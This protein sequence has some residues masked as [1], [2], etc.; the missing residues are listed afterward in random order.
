MISESRD[1]AVYT[2]VTRRL[3][4]LR[5]LASRVRRYLPFVYHLARTDMKGEHLDTILGQAWMV[6]NPLLMAGVYY[7][8]VSILSDSAR[9]SAGFFSLLVAGLFLFF[10]CRNSLTFGSS[11]I[12]KG[13]RLILNA[14][15]PRVLLPMA[16]VTSALFQFIPTIVVF[17]VIHFVLGQAFTVHMLW[18]PLLILIATIFNLGIAMLGA[19][20]NVFVRDI[21][22]LI[23]Y[24]SRIW[25]YLT[26]VLYRYDDVPSSIAVFLKLNPVYPLFVA[27][28]DALS[29]A[30]P[31]LSTI[32]WAALIALA[33]FVCGAYLFLTREREFAVR[34]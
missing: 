26:P 24:I 5:A 4:P 21:S 3:P 33:A 29:G 11:S 31:S 22:N 14:S 25:L 34:L 12:V 18:L 1:V 23:P 16:A 6:V 20:L 13:G 19:T 7:V 10:Y 15:F 2:P 32:G 9:G 28:Q 17:T 8:L 30:A 27:L